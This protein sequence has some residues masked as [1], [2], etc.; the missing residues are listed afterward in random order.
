MELNLESNLGK[1]FSK[2]V[3]HSHAPKFSTAGLLLA[4]SGE[5]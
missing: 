3:Y 1:S 2:T 4:E 5:L